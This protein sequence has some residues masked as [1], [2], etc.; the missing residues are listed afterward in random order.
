[1]ISSSGTYAHVES[2]VASVEEKLSTSP[3]AR[4]YSSISKQGRFWIT[5]SSLK[6]KLYQKGVKLNLKRKEG[7]CHL[8]LNSAGSTR[9][10]PES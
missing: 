2:K 5:R 8:N 7:V 3:P 10:E 4:A 6:C 9:E 1:M